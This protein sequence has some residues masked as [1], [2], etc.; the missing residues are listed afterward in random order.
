MRTRSRTHIS[1]C[2]RRCLRLPGSLTTTT[3]SR[4][5]PA[6]TRLRQRTAQTWQDRQPVRW[7]HSRTPLRSTITRGKARDRAS[8]LIRPAYPLSG[9]LWRTAAEAL[10]ITLPS[11]TW[12]PFS[13][14]E[15]D[16]VPAIHFFGFDR[17]YSLSRFAHY[18]GPATLL[19]L[20]YAAACLTSLACVR[21]ESRF[22]KSMKY[23]TFA[24]P[25]CV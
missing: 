23:G 17:L 13:T 20:H 8:K 12:P 1:R 24:Q 9:A 14:R 2:R 21:P 6:P 25:L 22:T 5:T 15:G 11:T 16:Y 19:C 10:R 4:A 18:G 7:G 3:A